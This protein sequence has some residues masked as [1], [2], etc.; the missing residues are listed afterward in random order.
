MGDTDP[1]FS[2]QRPKTTTRNLSHFTQSTDR[3][4]KMGAFE[5]GAEVIPSSAWLYGQGED[6]V[7]LNL[8]FSFIRTRD[9]KNLLFCIYLQDKWCDRLHLRKRRRERHGRVPEKIVLYHTKLLPHGPA[10]HEGDTCSCRK[11]QAKSQGRNKEKKWYGKL[12]WIFSHHQKSCWIWIE[13]RHLYNECRV[14]E[15][16]NTSPILS[17]YLAATFAVFVCR[18][19]HLFI[20]YIVLLLRV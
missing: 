14:R 6:S 3:D 13:G 5:Y 12:V 17:I 19:Y 7:D 15:R 20:T 4:L 2:E 18:S 11:L 1:A 16:M 9:D 10:D 8:H